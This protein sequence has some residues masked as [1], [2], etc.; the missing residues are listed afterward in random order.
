MKCDGREVCGYC[1]K[2]GLG[3]KRHTNESMDMVERGNGSSADLS[4]SKELDALESGTG[5]DWS[6]AMFDQTPEA[7]ARLQDVSRPQRVDEPDWTPIEPSLNANLFENDSFSMPYDEA[8][9]TISSKEQPL[10]GLPQTTE[11]NFDIFGLPTV[12]SIPNFRPTSPTVHIDIGNK[13]DLTADSTDSAQ[14]GQV[15]TLASCQCRDDLTRLVPRVKN[16]VQEGQLNEVFKITRE[17]M[18]RCRTIIACATCNIGCTDL[19]CLTAVFQQ[20]GDCFQYIANPNLPSALNV[21]FGG[22]EV[23]IDDPRL[24]AMLVLNLVDDARTLLDAISNRGQS[25]LRALVTP[26][27]FATTNIAHLESVIA[28][29]RGLLDKVAEDA[30]VS[31]SP[32]VELTATQEILS[33]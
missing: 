12:W 23:P 27:L 19:I 14:Q 17:V 29:F 18:K 15:L 7:S 1:E 2:R 16:A 22:L 6:N 10:G 9:T 4:A 21:N 33:V 24:R 20:T 26:T 25:M 11:P 31:P 32:S 13:K 3:C 28:E 8:T 5:F 30:T